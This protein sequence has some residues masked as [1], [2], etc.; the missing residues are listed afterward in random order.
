M[1]S[2]GFINF[3]LALAVAH[4]QGFPAL[5]LSVRMTALIAAIWRQFWTFFC[6]RIHPTQHLMVNCAWHFHINACVSFFV[7]K[8]K[9]S[10]LKCKLFE[11]FVHLQHW[12]VCELLCKVCWAIPH[13][14]V[15]A[16]F[17]KTISSFAL[18]TTCLPCF[19]IRYKQE[20]LY[21]PSWKVS[22]RYRSTTWDVLHLQKVE[23]ET[24]WRSPRLL[25]SKTIETVLRR[26]EKR[27][28]SHWMNWRDPSSFLRP[29][30][31]SRLWV[32][33]PHPANHHGQ[34]WTTNSSVHRWGWGVRLDLQEFDDGG[35]SQD[36][37]RRSGSPFVRCFC[38]SPSTCLWEDELGKPQDIPQGGEAQVHQNRV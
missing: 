15:Q 28:R 21:S 22:L 23:V 1:M 19:L 30:H 37:R 26:S 33:C 2:V 34:G 12:F 10:S 32:C 35:S 27:Y 7:G 17:Q 31:K 3:F 20:T 18:S 14:F 8:K 5:W 36:G 9:L 24:E 4:V 38:G 11:V 13:C 16:L 25:K 6:A 29:D